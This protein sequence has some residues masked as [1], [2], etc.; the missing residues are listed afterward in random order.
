[1]DGTRH[2]Y[3][4]ARE[5]GARRFVYCST[6]GVH[7]NVDP[8]PADEDAP[9]R[10]AD[11]YQRTK[12]EGEVELQ[13]C[14]TDDLPWSIVRPTAIYG[15]GDPER[16]VM[17]YRRVLKGT[18]PMFGAGT[19]HYH[20]VYVDNLVD[21]FL[22]TA[23]KDEAI[24]RTYLGGDAEHLSIRDLVLRIAGALGVEVKIVRLPFWPLYGIACVVEGV[25][26]PLKL[27]PPIFR[28]R[29]DW[30]RQN[31]AFDI[32][33]ARNELGYEPRIGIDEGLRLTGEWYREKGYL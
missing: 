20:P 31:R 24:G 11:Y 1:M 26:T 28:R 10:P 13:R 5:G 25:C 7:G 21:L 14:S 6:C 29:V 2:A 15:P 23:E 19:A 4:A 32:S 9:I 3:E 22:L 12:Y 18:F 33:R 8:S 16:F 30:F 27:K 17:L